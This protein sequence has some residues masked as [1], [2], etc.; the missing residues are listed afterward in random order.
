[1]VATSSQLCTHIRGLNDLMSDG[2]WL[3]LAVA[4]YACSSSSLRDPSGESSNSQYAVQAH[5]SGTRTQ[6]Q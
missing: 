2:A 6:G 5:D 1:M 3:P 4:A